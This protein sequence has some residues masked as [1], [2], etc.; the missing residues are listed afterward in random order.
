VLF[1]VTYTDVDSSQLAQDVGASRFLLKTMEPAKFVAAIND[2]I[3]QFTKE[4]LPVPIKPAFDDEKFDKLHYRSVVN[5]LSQKV[6]ELNELNMALWKS[7]ERYR[8]IVEGT[9]DAIITIDDDLNITS[10]NHGAQLM[11]GYEAHEIVGKS[12]HKMVPERKLSEQEMIF[13]HVREHGFLNAFETV[14]LTKNGDEAQVEISLGEMKSKA[15]QSIGT[16]AIVRDIRERK[17]TEKILQ[18]RT[19]ALI[20]KVKELSCL[21]EISSILEKH[22]IPLNEILKK[23]LYAIPKGL[24]DPENCCVKI[25]YRNREF[26]TDNF[27]ETGWNMIE[28]LIVLNAEVGFLEICKLSVEQKDP[29]KVFSEDEKK[30]I[31]AIVGRLT[32]CIE[33][34]EVEQE[35]ETIEKQL[36]QA[37]KMEAVGT[38]A[39]GIAHDFNN[40]LTPILGYSTIAL[41]SLPEDSEVR[42]QLTYV[43]QA[44]HRAADLVKQIL[45]FSRRSELE[46]TP[47]QIQFIIKE[48]LKLLRASIPANISIEQVIDNKCHPVLADPTQIHQI[49]MNLCTNAYHAMHEKGGVISVALFEKNIEADENF[50]NNTVTD[51]NYVVL[52][53]RDTGTGMNWALQERIFEPY[54]TTKKKGKGTGLGLS[55]VHGLVSAMGGHIAVD[56]KLGQGTTFR[57][58]LPVFESGYI[59]EVRKE[60]DALNGGHERILVV[61]DEELIV[62]LDIQMLQS[63]GYRVTAFTS[64][65]KALEAFTEAPSSFDLVITDMAMPFMDG[66]EFATALFAIRADIPIIL[67]TGFSEIV[68]CEKAKQIGFKEYLLKPVLMQTLSSAIRKVLDSAE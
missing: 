29:D 49:L 15:G 67:R 50:R 54:F 20:T 43:I 65:L 34:I 11:F 25:V 23:S 26:L 42:K 9:A 36:I 10:W 58:Y 60:Y 39:G 40:I 35:K 66:V 55:V 28:Q 21:Y 13:S 19:K 31:K 51:G 68:D 59:D 16:S 46:K 7:E 38:L 1:S 2:V 64:S 12:I 56:S 62:D 61:D 27:K 22:D 24:D 44:S 63:L 17:K 18:E 53:V 4:G 6:V 14:R 52:E 3:Q 45:A 8:T 47:V 57:I 30:L 33:R 32:S 48:A 5:K 41:E 37:Q